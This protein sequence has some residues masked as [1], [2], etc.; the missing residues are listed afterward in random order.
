MLKAEEQYLLCEHYMAGLLGLLSGDRTRGYGRDPL[1]DSYWE[2]SSTSQQ[3]AAVC[4]DAI[5]S[6]D[7]LEERSDHGI[8]IF[9]FEWEIFCGIKGLRQITLQ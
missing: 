2:L 5:W 3:F 7:I 6:R 4:A 9:T 8:R 1:C